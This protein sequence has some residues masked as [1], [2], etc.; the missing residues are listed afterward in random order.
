MVATH[1]CEILEENVNCKLGPTALFFF[2]FLFEIIL[3][4]SIKIQDIRIRVYKIEF[5]SA[6]NL[7]E[8]NFD[9]G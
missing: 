7:I 2:L 1:D 5:G 8:F 9:M 3:K 6:F 4:V